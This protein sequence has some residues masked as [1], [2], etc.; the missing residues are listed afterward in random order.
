MKAPRRQIVVAPD[1]GFALVVLSTIGLHDQAM[2]I[3]HKIDYPGSNRHLPTKLGSRKSTV[4]QQLPQR[5]LSTRR[6]LAQRLR[7]STFLI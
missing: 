2:L 1:I 4:P 3:T 5:L 7:E 6:A